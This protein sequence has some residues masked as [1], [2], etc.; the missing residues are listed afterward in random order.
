MPTSSDVRL[1]DDSIQ[2]EQNYLWRKNLLFDT[3]EKAGGSQAFVVWGVQPADTG[4]QSKCNKPQA[5]VSSSQRQLILNVCDSTELL[6]DNP[7]SWSQL[8]LDKAFDASSEES[9]TFL[10][11]FCD[12]LFDQEFA[13]FVVSNYTCPMKRFEHWLQ[14]QST[15]E[16]QDTTYSQHCG[17][18][19]AIPVHPDHF[20]PCI[21]AWANQVGESSILSYEDRVQI[22]LLPFSSRVR[23]DDHYDT[24]DDEWQRIEAWMQSEN[25]KA[26][27]GVDQGYFSSFDF[28]W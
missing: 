27:S 5:I 19:S 21:I 26:P 15:S 20:N 24:L 14:D 2:F 13:D 9:Q 18:A 6:V 25:K 1:L 16:E 17:E 23:Y 7:A 28:W 8:V 22:I 3:L 10:F 4:D 11:D 12:R